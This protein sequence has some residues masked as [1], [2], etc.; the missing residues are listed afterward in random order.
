MREDEHIP[1]QPALFYPKSKLQ[2]LL[3]AD[4]RNPNYF[5]TPV[6]CADLVDLLLL[7]PLG[8]VFELTLP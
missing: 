5:F 1:F 3:Q 7:A 2:L 6:L 8:D 4:C